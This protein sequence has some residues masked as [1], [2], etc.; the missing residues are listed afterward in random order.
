MAGFFEYTAYEPPL[1]SA[2]I[3][4]ISERKPGAM[5]SRASA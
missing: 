3:F 2:R 5:S 4:L 1:I